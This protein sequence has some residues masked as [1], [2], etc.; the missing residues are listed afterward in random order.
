MAR[1]PL[2]PVPT[3]LLEVEV[4]GTARRAAP[5]AALVRQSDEHA[6][7]GSPHGEL[8]ERL[9]ATGKAGEVHT[10]PDPGSGPRWLVGIGAGDPAS[11]RAGGAAFIR[12]V[13]AHLAAE[14]DAGARPP[15]TVQAE[16]PA[17]SSAGELD[18]F[19]TGALL[20]GYR[21]VVSG[22]PDP[23]Q[24]RTLRVLTPHDRAIQPYT[25][26]AARARELAAAS[27]LAR[28]LA[29]TPSNVKNPGWLAGVAER[30]AGDLPG[31]TATV[32]D[33]GWLAEQGFGGM[34]AVGGGS[35]SPPRLIELAYRPRGATG[36]LLLVGKGITFDT[37]GI[38]IKPAEG[39]PMMR[40]DMAGGGAV[41]AAVRA[42]AALRLGV[43]V[44]ALVP[45]AEN[46][47]SGAAYRPGDVVRHYGGTTTE[48]TNTDA[49]GRMVL[50]DALAYGIKRYAP[51]AVV[52]VATLTGAMK[53]SLGLRTGGLFASD[54]TLAERVRDAGERTGEAWW[55]MPLVEDYAEAVRS[56]IADLRQAPS[57]PGGIA[58]ALF[59]REFTAGLPWA[60]LD[61]AGPA[62]ADRNYSE[63]VPGGTGFAARTLV[64]LVSG[65]AP[66]TNSRKA[67]TA[68][69]GS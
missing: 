20:G 51:D 38:S 43:R 22:E 7:N 26:V 17:E 34:L 68:G 39:M 44:T 30:L 60:H 3:R 14:R 47:V 46:H 56:E 55:R 33:E 28:D 6:A 58:A 19:L 54:D 1:S 13:N 25:E 9:G 29:N 27:A 41:I 15:R 49:E 5:L 48:V 32:R 10:V 63:V 18:A 40:T 4:A 12:A 31:L 64:E 8:I 61:I 57:G 45:A 59:L 35:A 2:P 23:P 42:I 50:A 24:A 16:L 37:G 69:V 65:W 62:R 52:D 21:Y 11:S 67:A 53:V 36:H 66:V